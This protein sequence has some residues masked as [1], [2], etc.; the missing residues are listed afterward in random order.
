MLR[1]GLVGCGANAQAIHIPIWKRMNQAELVA[2]YDLNKLLADKIASELGVVSSDSVD[3][4]LKSEVDVI[5]ICTPTSTHFELAMKALKAGHHVLV[6]KPVTLTSEEA[7]NLIEE[8]E[9]KGVKIG[10]VQ[11]YLYSRGL[12]KLFRLLREKAIGE[13]LHMQ[14][15][16]PFFPMSGWPSKREHGGTLWELGIHPAYIMAFLMG[17]PDRIKAVGRYDLRGHSDIQISLEKG[18]V[19][20]SIH[21]SPD[22]LR[23]YSVEIIGDNGSL[24]LD[25]VTD[26]VFKYRKLGIQEKPWLGIGIEHSYNDVGRSISSVTCAIKKAIRYTVFNIKEFNQYKLFYD[27][28]QHIQGQSNFLSTVD[29]GL[30]S[31]CTLETTA[32]SLGIDQPL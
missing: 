15:S 22:W 16:Y 18:D 8:K 9:K 19:T 12:M 5:D 10:V 20:G 27:F 3:D 1:I 24:S 4:L 23:S 26:S 32:K 21:L 13:V 11:H 2:V 17:A 31:L 7:R 28:C 6:E 25:L 14:I 30:I 29:V